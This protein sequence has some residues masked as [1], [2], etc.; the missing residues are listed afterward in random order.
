MHEVLL[1]RAAER[2]LKP[3]RGLSTNESSPICKHFPK[4]HD[5]LGVR[6]L[7]GRVAIDVTA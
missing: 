3:F 6:K 2:D 5:L 7:Q 1:E 4:T